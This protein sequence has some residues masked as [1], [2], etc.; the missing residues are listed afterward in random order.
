MRKLHYSTYIVEIRGTLEEEWYDIRNRT[1]KQLPVF[2][3]DLEPKDNEKQ[4]IYTRGEFGISISVTILSLQDR[5]D[6]SP[7]G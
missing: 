6:D 3:G 5:C 4:F 7:S 2:I 1:K